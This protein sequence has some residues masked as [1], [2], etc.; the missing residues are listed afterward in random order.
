MGAIK[1]RAISLVVKA[2]WITGFTFLSSDASYARDNSGSDDIFEIAVPAEYKDLIDETRTVID[3]YYQDQRIGDGYVSYNNETLEFKTPESISLLVPELREYDPITKALKGLL[4]RHSDKICSQAKPR[5]DCGVIDPEIAGIIFDESQLSVEI[6]VNPVFTYGDT[7][8]ARYLPAPT[9]APAIISN[10]DLRAFH[11]F[12]RNN[13]TIAGS[14]NLIAGFGRTSFSADAFV[15]G[16]DNSF[17]NSATVAH[18]GRSTEYAGG[19]LPQSSSLGLARSH[20][21]VGI[22]V[23]STLKTRLDR[24]ALQTSDIPVNVST[25]AVVEILQGSRVLDIQTVSP[26]QRALDTQR[27]PNGSYNVTLRITENGETREESRFFHT[28]SNLPPKNTTIWEVEAG[29]P[30]PL[31]NRDIF[32]DVPDTQPLISARISRRIGS[33]WGLQGAATVSE[34]IQF[35]EFATAFVGESL[36][37]NAG[38]LLSADNETGFFASGRYLHDKF[39]LT[40]NYR[41]IDSNSTEFLR[42]EYDPFGA[43]FKQ[44]TASLRFPVNIVNQGPARI[45]FRGF[46]RENS[47]GSKT[48]YAGPSV[49]QT[50]LRKGDIRLSANFRA[51][52]GNRQDNYFAGL[53]MLRNF[54]TTSNVRRNLNADIQYRQINPS[55]AGDKRIE[56]VVNVN[57]NVAH[58]GE[59]GAPSWNYF[60]GLRYDDGLGVRGGV[61]LE[62][63]DLR[64]GIEGRNNFQQQNNVIATLQ[65][66][67]V[68]TP[69]HVSLTSDRARS[70]AIVKLNGL[71]TNLVEA[72]ANR[73]KRYIKTKS[74]SAEN[75]SG[76]FLPL[77]PYRIED[78]SIRPIES[79]DLDYE[80]HKDRIV[81]YP[82]NVSQVNRTLKKVKIIIGRL[83]DEAGLPI[84]DVDIVASHKLTSTDSEGYFQADIPI[85]ETIHVKDGEKILCSL[86]TH[87][88]GLHKEA[89]YFNAGDLA[90]SSSQLLA[91]GS[92][93]HGT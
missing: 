37:V 20:R 28:G 18:I 8:D 4:P 56:P 88:L 70:G 48:W 62:R 85:G 52:F 81:V 47:L 61:Q 40:A 64:V 30:V 82:G 58:L 84:N 79:A 36:S 90:C 43:S 45:G 74:D 17:L 93:S 33:Q 71:T 23:G 68:L 55:L 77:P 12:D 91:L 57:Y 14:V 44:G 60:A 73:I 27:L 3:I 46:F 32:A 35:A 87:A 69:N 6:F 41:E 16:N 76:T 22:F 19:F 34:D 26:D 39:T 83:V 25:D 89:I 65:S 13:S 5:P 51:Q 21:M 50:L 31:S 10:I 66:G 15:N 11:D 67:I 42:D 72:R 49:S 59:E 24:E 38:A 1:L 53:R 7:N 75:S 2:V 29:L 86:S 80:H 78:V 54:G 9:V 92:T 63:E